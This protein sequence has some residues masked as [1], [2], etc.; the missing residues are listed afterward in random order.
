MRPRENSPVT[1]MVNSTRT[2]TEN[3][4][5]PYAVARLDTGFAKYL[6]SRRGQIIKHQPLR[7]RRRMRGKGDCLDLSSLFSS[8]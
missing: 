5:G 7:N 4:V 3:Q 1:T 8:D 2:K 6:A